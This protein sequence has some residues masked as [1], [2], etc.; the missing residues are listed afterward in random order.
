MHDYFGD[1]VSTIFVKQIRNI[2]KIWKSLPVNM[3]KNVGFPH[4]CELRV[5]NYKG[6]RG[7]GSRGAGQ[8]ELLEGEQNRNKK[9][10]RANNYVKHKK[11][12]S[13]VLSLH[14]WFCKVHKNVAMHELRVHWWLKGNWKSFKFIL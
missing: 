10:W 1:W 2:I 3:Q 4:L 5:K 11:V 12:M 7:S 13:V 9:A 6:L 14:I 8:W